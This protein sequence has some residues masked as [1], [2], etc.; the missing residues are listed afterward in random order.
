[1]EWCPMK[2]ASF[3]VACIY[4]QSSCTLFFASIIQYNCSPTQP[5][6][7]LNSLTIS[8]FPRTWEA[9][10]FFFHS[11]N[12]SMYL[13]V[14]SFLLQSAWAHTVPQTWGL[15][16]Q[17]PTC[18]YLF[19]AWSN[20]S[21]LPAKLPFFF[22]TVKSQFKCNVFPRK[23]HGYHR[24]SFWSMPTSLQNLYTVLNILELF[25]QEC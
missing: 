18:W 24:W 1:M 16:H 2:K 8:D 14:G 4:I 3:K 17:S 11:R 9:S 5:S 25:V 13:P 21:F 20:P 12:K 22:P 19:P 10:S 15:P 6:W 7:S 23:L